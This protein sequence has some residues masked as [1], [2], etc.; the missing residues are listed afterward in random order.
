M[1]GLR[2]PGTTVTVEWGYELHS[3]NLTARNWSKV[4]SGKPLRIRGR[5][6]HDEGE[7]F[8]DYWTFG[9]GLDGQLMVEYGDNGGTGFIGKLSD[10]TINGEMTAFPIARACCERLTSK[11]ISSCV[12][13]SWLH[14]IRAAA[15]TGAPCALLGWERPAALSRR[16]PLSAPAVAPA[17]HVGYIEASSPPL[18]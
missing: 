14:R 9:G 16:A 17:L 12:G 8:W 6:Y 15:D 13:K 2:A 3:I 10:A 7:F 1:I 11:L 18:R 4:K 5:G